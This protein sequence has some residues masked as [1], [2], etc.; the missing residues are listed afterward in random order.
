MRRFIIC[1]PTLTQILGEMKEDST[2]RASRAYGR[3]EKRIQNFE[4][5]ISKEETT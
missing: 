1:R 4:W 3:D 2:G 5:K